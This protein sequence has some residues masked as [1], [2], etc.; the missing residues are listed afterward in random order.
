MATTYPP[1]LKKWK[2]IAQENPFVELREKVLNMDGLYSYLYASDL[3]FYHKPSLPWVAVSSTAYQILGS[4]CPMVAMHSNFVEKFG[5][6]IM[7]YENEKGMIANIES[8]FK[9]DEKY[10][11]FLKEQKRYVEE[12]SGIR[13]AEK[14][15]ELFKKL[16]K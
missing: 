2:K 9:E 4:G 13:I 10:R 6:A 3:F 14:F 8:V 5:K 7:T 1:S 12:N 16:G 11:G 15:L